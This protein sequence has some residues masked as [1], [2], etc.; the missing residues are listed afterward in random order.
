MFHDWHQQDIVAYQLFYSKTHIIELT[1]KKMIA[2]YPIHYV[3][4]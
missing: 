4:L 1:T 2:Y 3:N